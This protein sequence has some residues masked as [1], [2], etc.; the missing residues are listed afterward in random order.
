MKRAFD[1]SVLTNLKVRPAKI[2]NV[3]YLSVRLLKFARGDSERTALLST[4]A[5]TSPHLMLW[6]SDWAADD[7]PM[8]RSLTGVDA[9]SE[10][11]A[12]LNVGGWALFFFEN[13]YAAAEAQGTMPAAA[14]PD[15][16][17][18]VLQQ[19]RADAGIWSW[20]DDRDWLLAV[21]PGEP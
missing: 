12:E 8:W 17:V 1:P 5:S 15:D 13:A 10:F 3:W 4:L 9:L 7:G 18:R 20:Y 21:A 11:D 2:P 6:L 14:E 16:A 19:L